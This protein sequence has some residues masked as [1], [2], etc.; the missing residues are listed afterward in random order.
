MWCRIVHS[1]WLLVFLGTWYRPTLKMEVVGPFVIL[2]HVFSSRRPFFV[3]WDIISYTLVK[4]NQHIYYL[5]LQGGK[6]WT[7]QGNRGF[8]CW[9]LAWLTLS[10][11]R[12]SQRVPLECWSTFTRQSHKSD[13]RWTA[14][15]R[16]QQDCRTDSTIVKN[17]SWEVG[18]NRELRRMSSSGMWRHVGLL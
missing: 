1:V 11:W 14:W 3:F 12:W 7:E 5:H 17:P 18:A 15:H 13:I 16:I 2:L 8:T 4:V 6:E 9:L 10:P